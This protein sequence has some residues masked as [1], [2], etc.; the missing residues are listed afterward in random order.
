ML[1]PWLQEMLCIG[2][3]VTSELSSAGWPYLHGR[4]M[5][6]MEGD[7]ISVTVHTIVD[8]THNLW[9]I[10]RLWEFRNGMGELANV[11]ARVCVCV[12]V[13]CVR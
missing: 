11:R 7:F 8:V 3:D 5:L 9:L 1:S 12:C 2:S 13:P 4:L 6:L 10:K